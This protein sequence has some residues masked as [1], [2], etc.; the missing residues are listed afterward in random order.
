[1][2]KKRASLNPPHVRITPDEPGG[3]GSDWNA[4][5]VLAISLSLAAVLVLPLF[6]C[7][8][9]RCILTSMRKKKE[10]KV[11]DERLEAI[12]EAQ[13]AAA[14][15]AAEAGDDE[16]SLAL[17][18][19]L[20]S[21]KKERA[22]VAKGRKPALERFDHKTANLFDA[23][24]DDPEAATRNPTDPAPLTAPASAV[25][26]GNEPVIYHPDAS[27]EPRGQR[28][29]EHFHEEYSGEK[30]VP[31]HASRPLSQEP[32]GEKHAPPNASRPLSQEPFAVDTPLVRAEAFDEPLQEYPRRP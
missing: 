24:A 22:A 13:A 26:S 17:R 10:R 12:M 21:T 1:M 23:Y 29:I 4:T 7:L 3:P 20:E 16:R 25:S 18:A 5:K 6:L 14:R 30:H 31:P 11:A 15:E 28:E 27:T 32:Y 2:D 8:A 9:R 19:Q